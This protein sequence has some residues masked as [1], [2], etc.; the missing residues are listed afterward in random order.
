MVVHTHTRT[1]VTEVVHQYDLSDELRG[2]AIEHAVYCP[3]QGR[4]T[5]VVEWDDDA[6]VGQL[7]PI[8]LLFTAKHT[9]K[10]ANKI[11]SNKHQLPK[12]K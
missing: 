4:P 12:S 11:I 3:E 2:R 8:Q 10:Q 7:L 9:Q 1:F 5:L 6:G